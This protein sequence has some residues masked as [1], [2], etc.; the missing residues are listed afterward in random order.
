MDPQ[1]ITIEERLGGFR[2][3]D[4]IE[5]ISILLHISDGFAI[6][7]DQL[8]EDFVTFSHGQTNIYFRNTKDLIARIIGCDYNAVSKF[9]T[10]QFVMKPSNSK[11]IGFYIVSLDQ[12]DR[13]S[14]KYSKVSRAQLEGMLAQPIHLNMKA[15]KQMVDT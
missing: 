3:S 10:S 15:L 7:N 9:N 6:D 5:K 1:T 8:P 4:N 14:S 13:V 12:V 11:T 2:E